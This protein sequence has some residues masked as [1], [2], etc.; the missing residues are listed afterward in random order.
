VRLVA[1]LLLALVVSACGG[2][3][4]SAPQ[5]AAPEQAEE[6]DAGGLHIHGLAVEP[7][8]E[9]L[10]IATHTGLWRVADGTS[11]AERVGDV[12]HDFMGFAVAGPGHFV[13]SGHPDPAQMQAQSLPPDLGLIESRDGGLSW[14]EVALAGE[15]DFHV[16]RASG[17]GFAGLEATSGELMVGSADGRSWRVVAT[18]VAFYDV[19][20]APQRPDTLLASGVEGLYRSD[21]GGESWRQVTSQ[22]GLVSWPEGETVYLLD[23]EGGIHASADGGATFERRGR[24]ADPVGLAAADASTVYVARQDGS[25]EMSRDGGR[26]W[27]L[28]ARV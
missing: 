27:T 15:A 1:L 9:S 12:R 21:D 2:T 18:P 26:T 3:G 4:E 6:H 16:L 8:D 25:V 20:F 22:T 28:R 14:T 11:E 23:V 17:D 7:S 13:A 5:P 19:V 10:L 24:V